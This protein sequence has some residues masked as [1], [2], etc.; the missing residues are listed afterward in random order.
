MCMWTVV[1]QWMPNRV[2]VVGCK[3]ACN[4]EVCVSSAITV[5]P[6]APRGWYT[7]LEECCNLFYLCIF[8]NIVDLYSRG[9][10]P[11]LGFPRNTCVLC[12]LC[13]SCLLVVVF[14]FCVV[15]FLSIYLAYLQSNLNRRH[16]DQPTRLCVEYA[17]QVRY[18]GLQIRFNSSGQKR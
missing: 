9:F 17:F 14:C 13:P 16:T 3:E 4:K 2:Y 10:P 1:E 18:D 6:R 7:L 12:I 11:R 8:S 15:Y 5:T